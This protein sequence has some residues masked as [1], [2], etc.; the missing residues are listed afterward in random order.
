MS[1]VVFS[2]QIRITSRG[3][4]VVKKGAILG[5]E[6]FFHKEE[7]QTIKELLMAYPTIKIEERTEKDKNIVK[8]NLGNYNTVNERMP[9]GMEENINPVPDEDPDSDDSNNEDQTPDEDPVQVDAPA[10][11]S[12]DESVTADGTEI[13]N[14]DAAPNTED[15]PAEAVETSNNEDQTPDE[16]PVQVDA[17]AAEPVAQAAGTNEA[18]SQPKT[19]N[20]QPSG[21]SKKNKN[22]NRGKDAAEVTPKE[23]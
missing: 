20:Q 21:S 22:K 8:L 12:D 1:E 3:R 18:V 5:P 15:D 4:F 10:A 13:G 11:Q 14:D 7:V 2:K 23:A 16:D 19:N 6:A 17:P 9:I